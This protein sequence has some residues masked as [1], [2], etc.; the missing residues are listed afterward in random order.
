MPHITIECSP[1]ILDRVDS[2]TLVRHVHDS[3]EAL[4]V[5]SV[6]GLRC[7]LYSGLCWCIGDMKDDRQAVHVTIRARKRPPEVRRQIMESLH[8]AL[9]LFLMERLAGAPCLVSVDMLDLDDCYLT[10]SI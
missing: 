9:K 4:Q 7:R 8:A 6:S 1:G 10:A 2:G 5:Y 3:L